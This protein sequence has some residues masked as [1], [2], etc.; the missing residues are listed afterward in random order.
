[1]DRFDSLSRRDAVTKALEDAYRQ[2]G[3]QEPEAALTIAALEPPSRFFRPPMRPTSRALHR[4]ERR[5]ERAEGE[6]IVV[7]VERPRRQVP[8]LLELSRARRQCG[9]PTCARVAAKF[10]SMG[11]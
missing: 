10:S 11:E 5:V 1:M 3:E 4:G 8:A 2:D 9:A 6:D 7:T